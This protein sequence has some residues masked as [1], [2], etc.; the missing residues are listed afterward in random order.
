MF[1]INVW[2]VNDRDSVRF[3]AKSEKNMQTG[4]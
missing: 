4:L 2:V 3:Y 1:G